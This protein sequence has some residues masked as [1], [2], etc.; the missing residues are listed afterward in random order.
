MKSKSP[1]KEKQR[2]E[3]LV[4]Q[5]IPQTENL[6]TESEYE[7][8][9]APYFDELFSPKIMDEAHKP[10]YNM[11]VKKY[12]TQSA[13]DISCRTGQTLKVLSS[14]GVKKLTGIDVSPAMI[15][16]GKKKLPK[17]EWFVAPLNA[18]AQA[19]SGKYD[20]IVCSK[21]SLTL[22]LDDE[23][24]LNIFI[25]LKELLNDNGI[26][27]VE[28]LNYEKIWKHKERFMPVMDRSDGRS[29]KLFFYLNDFHEELVVRNLVRFTHDQDEWF[30]K[31]FSIPIRPLMHAELEFFVKEAQY[32][33]YG[34]F[35]SYSGTPYSVD[36]SPYAILIAKK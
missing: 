12:H 17:A 31:V 22:V 14:L 35:G 25:Q 36:R 3:I 18:A 7:D 32:S 19:V 2:T 34:F 23:S 15:A 16:E 30:A 4:S 21:D 33:K 13:C 10:F 11:L 28:V 1:I 5:N 6:L 20:L 29:P 9:I 24:L 26:L 8:A 27:I